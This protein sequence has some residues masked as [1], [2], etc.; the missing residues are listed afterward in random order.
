MWKNVCSV[1][2]ACVDDDVLDYFL[3]TIAVSGQNRLWYN[4]KTRPKRAYFQ[5]VKQIIRSFF[6]SFVD[7]GRGLIEKPQVVKTLVKNFFFDI[8]NST[9]VLFLWTK[10]SF[11]SI[12]Y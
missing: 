9:K 4:P 5:M 8:F 6:P 2:A 10:S 1:A 11:V 7:C 12:C 3:A